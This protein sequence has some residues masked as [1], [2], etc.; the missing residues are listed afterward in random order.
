MA[1][2]ARSTSRSVLIGVGGQATGP[3]SL[4]TLQTELTSYHEVYGIKA[5]V[6]YRNHIPM[7]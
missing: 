6:Y 1:S 5:G 2:A 3:R 7:A 4:A